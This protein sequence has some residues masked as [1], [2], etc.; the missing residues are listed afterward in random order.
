VLRGDAS[1]LP[2]RSGVFAAV[3]VHH[4]LGHASPDERAAMA[5]EVARILAPKGWLEVR[6]F[7]RGDLRDG[8]GEPMGDAT[9]M[10][11]G[12]AQHY[13]AEGELR[14][15]FP[16]MEGDELV[17]ERRVRFARAPRRVV[18]LRLRAA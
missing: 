12:I 8:A 1:A 7:A 5:A 2:F 14:A 15:L 16:A 10:R 17:V 13:F 9:F 11:E 6:E 18:E 3:R 4:L